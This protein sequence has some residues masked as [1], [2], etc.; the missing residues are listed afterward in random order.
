VVVGC[1]TVDEVRANLA[2]A[3]G[4]AWMSDLEQRALEKRVAPRASAYDASREAPGCL[5]EGKPFT[6]VCGQR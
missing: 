5:A 4:W 6:F 1:S 3:A 2:A